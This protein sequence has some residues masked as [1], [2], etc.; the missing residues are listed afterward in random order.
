[1]M[2]YLLIYQYFISFSIEYHYSNLDFIIHSLL[3]LIPLLIVV[4]FFTL[5][6]RKA[7]A[8]IQRRKGPNIVGIL[9]FLQPFADGLKLVVKEIIIPTK[10][11]K[12]L[13]A[14]GPFL[15]LFLSF[16]G[17]LAI[18]F[19]IYTRVFDLNNSLL[20]ILVISS[21]GVYGILLSGWASN[22]KYALIGALRSVSQMISYEV[23]ISLIILPVVLF[24]NSLNLNIIIQAQRE[25]IWFFFPLLPI[26]IIFFISI[27][28]ET[29]RAPFDLPE[30]EAELVAGYNVEYSAIMFAA[31]FLGEYANIL[32]MSTLFV[33]FF[34][35]GGHFFL[36]KPITSGLFN[37]TLNSLWLVSIFTIKVI[38]VTFIFIFVR[39]NLPRFRFDQLMFIGW[40]IFLPLTLSFTFF[41]SGLLFSLK[42]LSIVQIPHFN[43]SFNYLTSFSLRF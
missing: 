23:S 25:T 9:G 16:I 41:F 29:N 26:A 12:F 33:I 4:A 3:T 2:A 39:A 8:S 17:W 31:F 1:M 36:T 13:F 6:E 40:K 35:G 30:A 15:T 14:F 18:P 42:G 5:A 19:E 11:N 22:S 27:L 43:A 7:M 38:S 20:Y 37:T 21:L 28:A 32:L 34:F 24:S 10:V